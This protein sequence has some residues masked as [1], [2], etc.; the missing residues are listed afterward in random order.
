M[1]KYL[2]HN[3]STLLK[4]NKRLAGCFQ[5]L[6]HLCLIELF[7]RFLIYTAIKRYNTDTS[8][9]SFKLGT[10]NTCLKCNLM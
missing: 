5:M 10:F 6:S 7:I 1:Q 8:K 3:N 4:S 9:F 2:L